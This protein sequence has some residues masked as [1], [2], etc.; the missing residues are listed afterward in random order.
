MTKKMC[1]TIGSSR[2]IVVVGANSERV[3]LFTLF[4]KDALAYGTDIT[5]RD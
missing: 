5:F 2:N 4:A 1:R 3:S